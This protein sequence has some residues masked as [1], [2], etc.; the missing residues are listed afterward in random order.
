MK[1][2]ILSILLGLTIVANSN[3][4]P[5]TYSG[6]VLGL[7]TPETISAASNGGVESGARVFNLKAN[8]IAQNT[9]FLKDRVPV[10][11]EF[12]PDTGKR[13]LCNTA[14][15]RK[16]LKKLKGGR[17]EANH[18]YFNTDTTPNDLLYPVQYASK[19]VSLPSAWDKSTG[20]NELLVL[21]IDTG[22]SYNHPDLK[23]NV[24]VNPREIPNNKIDDDQNG[25]V[26][27]VY[28]YNAI[29]NSGDP[30]DDNGHGTHVAGIIGAKGN[31]QSGTAGVAWN[32]KIV[33]A[34]FLSRIGIGSLSN[35]IKAIQYGIKL[36]E[37]GHNIVVSNN[38]WGSSGQSVVMS[39]LIRKAG[40][41][42]ILFVASAGNSQSNNDT[43]PSY[44]ASYSLPNVISVASVDANEN[45]SSFSNFGTTVH[46]AA[47]GRS[48]MSTA[49]NDSYVY[50]SGTSMAAPFVSG[51]AVLAQSVCGRP[52]LAT[53]LKDLIL[54]NV[55]P[56]PL[57][58]GLVSTSGIL[59]ANLSVS[60]AIKLCGG[61][62]PITTPT[63]TP[64]PTPSASSASFVANI[65]TLS[66]GIK[67]AM[68][69]WI[70]QLDSRTLLIQNTDS[71]GKTETVVQ[72]ADF[73]RMLAVKI[74]QPIY[75]IVVLPVGYKNLTFRSSPMTLGEKNELEF[76][77]QPR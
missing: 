57:L 76:V 20:S 58:S 17:C 53:E 42:G 66:S 62:V 45:L 71:N 35:A 37:A 55:K 54:Q 22:I 52:L 46:L 30:L 28:G 2:I 73:Q 77:T 34:K 4:Q 15:A 70:S 12:N 43:K 75:A 25:V 24:W 63:P 56:Q 60:S 23:D 74:G 72:G 59:N 9:F 50:M 40:D 69:V 32:V 6:A 39:D 49:R 48:I 13:K 21:L 68:V 14:K 27:D 44:P 47:P 16:L 51:V 33:S 8:K 3:A 19:M 61:A 10:G 29:T 31:N 64:I 5:I 38:S 65:K 26:D 1:R 7:R 18:A 41:L 36:K 67:G 11:K